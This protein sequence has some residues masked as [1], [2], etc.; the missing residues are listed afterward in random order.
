MHKDDRAAQRTPVLRRPCKSEPKLSKQ[1]EMEVVRAH[2][3]EEQ[4]ISQK[5]VERIEDRVSMGP[6]RYHGQ[7]VSPQELH[8]KHDVQCEVPR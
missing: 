1:R 6:S 2:G 4:S 8:P 3:C 5:E 7:C